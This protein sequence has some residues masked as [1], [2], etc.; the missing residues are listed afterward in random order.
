MNLQLPF[1]F[2][3]S[4]PSLV[5]QRSFQFAIGFAAN[6]DRND[7]SSDCIDSKLPE[8]MHEVNLATPYTLKDLVNLGAPAIRNANR[9]D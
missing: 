5:Y 9:G 6:R 7:F 8:T 2:A 4:L 3:R 1:K